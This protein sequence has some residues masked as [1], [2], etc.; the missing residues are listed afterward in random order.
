MTSPLI[1]IAATASAHHRPEP[2][3]ST[4]AIAAPATIAGVLGIGSGMQ[5]LVV[6]RLR[7]GQLRAPEKVGW[8]TAVDERCQHGP[9]EPDRMAKQLD[10][11]DGRMLGPDEL[12]SGVHQQVS[13]NREQGHA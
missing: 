8:D 5:D 10:A 1:R 12:E 11:A 9:A 3:P 13:A 2:M 4:P 6:E 7:Q